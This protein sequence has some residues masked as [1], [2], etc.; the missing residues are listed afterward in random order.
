MTHELPDLGYEFDALEPHIDKE[1]M[2]IH[3]DKHHAGY[4]KKLNDALEGHDDLKDK[5]VDELIKD[6]SS[7][8][9]DIKKAVRNNGG[10]HSNHTL[11]WSILKKDVSPSGE[12]KDAIHAKFGSGEEFKKQFHL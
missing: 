5:D 1:T 11:F 8:P 3:H 10:G 4:V 2:E 12:I 9:E 7:V 6:L